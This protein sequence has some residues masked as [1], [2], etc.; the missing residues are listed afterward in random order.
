M[1]DKIEIGEY[2]R[3]KDGRIAQ[4]K[5]IDYEAGIYRFDRIIYIN[6]FGMKENVLYNNEMFKKL[7]VKHSK[8]LIDLIE[9]KDVLKVRIDKEI[10]LFGMD[11]DTSDIKYKELIEYIENGEYELLEILTHEQFEANCYKVGGEE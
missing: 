9:N 5:S 10:M 4:I 3:T 7:I 1:E 6:D 8:Q 11:E 2:V